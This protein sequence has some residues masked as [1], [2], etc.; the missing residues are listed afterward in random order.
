MRIYQY[1]FQVFRGSGLAVTIIYMCLFGV[2]TT[3]FSQSAADPTTQAFHLE[4]ATFA[5][6]DRDDTDLSRSL[7]TYLAGKATQAEIA[8]NEKAIK[9]TLF[10]RTADL[11]LVI[12]EGFTDKAAAGSAPEITSYVIPNETSGFMLKNL[13][14]GYLRTATAYHLATGAFA[15]DKINADL[16]QTAAVTLTGTSAA[17]SGNLSVS[18]LFNFVGYPLLAL[19][20]FAIPLVLVEFTKTDI[21]RRN[22]C[23]PVNVT[24]FYLAIF[25]GCVTVALGIFVFF[26]LVALHAAGA[27][28]LFT[29]RGVLFLLNM[30]LCVLVSLALGFLISF[31]SKKGVIVTLANVI[32]LGC[33]FVGGAFVPQSMMGDSLKT[34]GSFTPMFWYAK[35]NDTLDSLNSF[36]AETLKG[37]FTA[38]AIEFLFGVAFVA[39]ALLLVK[40]RKQRT[41]AS[42]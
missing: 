7:T 29:T 27:D 9:D 8:D 21:R 3:F 6:I 37:Y 14:D 19:M 41:E 10:F 16:D 26:A 13:T 28:A 30:L 5:V 36:T 17:Q 15:F 25:A 24:R 32:S 40:G 12:P 11:I 38:L 1:F 39:V 22:L 34:F 18:S 20:L 31:V 35:A 2:L 42:S 23:A 4:G 33:A